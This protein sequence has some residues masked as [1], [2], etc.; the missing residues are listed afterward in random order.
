MKQTAVEWLINQVEKQGD[1]SVNVSIG[2]MQ[3]SIKEEDYLGL[4]E[5]SKEMEKQQQGYSEEEV[6]KMLEYAV[7]ESRMQDDKAEEYIVNETIFEF[8]NK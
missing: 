5:Q 2:R 1:A 8:K 7:H 4:I 6:E 3:I